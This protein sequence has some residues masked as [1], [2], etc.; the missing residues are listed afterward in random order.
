MPRQIGVQFHSPDSHL[1]LG[2]TRDDRGTNAALL[3][4]GDH[5]HVSEVC[6]FVIESLHQSEGL[7]PLGSVEQLEL[8]SQ[9]LCLVYGYELGVHLSCH[10]HNTL[11]LLQVR[12]VVEN[13]LTG[14]IL[15]HGLDIDQ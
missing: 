5:R 14:S 3:Q 4:L 15:T 10:E 12:V 7:L 6:W 8:V 11:V 13:Q 2:M 1:D 9:T